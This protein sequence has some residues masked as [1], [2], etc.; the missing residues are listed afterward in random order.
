MSEKDKGIVIK[1][2]N[3]YYRDHWEESMK[4]ILRF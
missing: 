2:E 1:T 4:R 3:E